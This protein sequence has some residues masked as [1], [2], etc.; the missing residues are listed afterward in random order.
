[1]DL[2]SKHIFKKNVI[3]PLLKNIKT[4]FLSYKSEEEKFFRFELEIGNIP[5]DFD[6]IIWL[7]EQDEPVKTYWSG[8]DKKFCV[9][10][11]GYADLLSSNL[12][13]YSANQNFISDIF[14]VMKS[15][16]SNTDKPV[17]YFGCIAFNENDRMD[18]LWESF[19]KAYFLVP[20]VEIYS[21][22]KKT[23]IACNIFYNPS[24][25]KS[26]KDIFEIT[27]Q[28]LEKIAPL[29]DLD[30]EAKIQYESRSDNPEKEKWLRNITRAISTFDFEQI[31]KIVLSRK[32]IFKLRKKISPVFL[33]KLLKNIN[34]QTYDFCFQNKENNGFIGC[35]PEL[36][37]SRIND[38]IYSEA[39]AGSVLRGSSAREEKELG[40]DLLKSKKDSDEYKF[41]FD[42]IKNELEKLCKAVKVISKKEI[43]KLSYVQHIYSSFEGTLKP[44]FD[45]F[46]IISSLHPTP[47]VSGYPKQNIREIIK[48]Y[49]TFYRGFYAGPVGWIGKNDS[50]FAVGIRSGV[51]NNNYLSVFSGAGIVK[52]SSPEEEWN[53]I[54]NKISPLLKILQNKK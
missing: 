2:K 14:T 23:F 35:T 53:E 49:E 44:D 1:M 11:I 25:G 7:L 12:K 46:R 28:F 17:K 42:Y 54:E 50:E 45:D 13:E 15:R 37:Y 40:E 16:I 26:K 30:E 8:R 10:G 38:K 36:L 24:D 34:V 29:N 51:L 39:L 9:A 6:P 27:Q 33:L 19:G 5:A 4:D 31:S 20:K 21:T 47:A 18:S 3:S 32:T 43:I 48:R 52:K 41:V 22:N